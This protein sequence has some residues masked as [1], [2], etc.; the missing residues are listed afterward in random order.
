MEMVLRLEEFVDAPYY[1]LFIVGP[2]ANVI[3]LAVIGKRSPKVLA[4]C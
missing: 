1:A 3:E 2:I 4:A